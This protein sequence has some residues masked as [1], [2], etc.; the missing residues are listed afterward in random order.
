MSSHTKDETA[1]QPKTKASDRSSRFPMRSPSP[2]SSPSSCSQQQLEL[3][4]YIDNSTWFRNKR[5][6]NFT[7]YAVID[8]ETHTICSG[9]RRFKGF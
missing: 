2:V 1:T 5:F 8:Y 7:E 3:F 4:N 9:C 6:Y